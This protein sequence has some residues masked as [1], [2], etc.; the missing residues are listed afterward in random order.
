MKKM[1]VAVLFILLFALLLTS[2]E[3]EL[4]QDINRYFKDKDYSKALELIE[5]GFSDYPENQNLIRWKFY[6]LIELERFDEALAHIEKHVTDKNELM[7][8]RLTVFKK[9]KKYQ[10]ALDLALDRE[11]NSKRRSPWSCFDIIELYLKVNNKE[12]ALD[13]LD[14]AVNRGFISYRFLYEDDFTLIQKEARFKNAVAKIKANIGIG[15]TAKNFSI[16]LLSGR[17]FSLSGQK[18][19]VVLVDFWAT[20]CG[21]CRAEIPNLKTYFQELN[22]K[23]FEIIGVSLDRD[24]QQ[25]DDYIE[26]EQLPWNISFSGQAWK[27][28]TAQLY[29]VNSIPSYWLIDKKGILRQFGLRGEELK[30]AIEELLAE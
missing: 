17:T 21:P 14:E 11:K 5:K 7:G 16:P 6:A 24:R 22:P 2:G 28:E 15:Q 30:K 10:E 13:W 25:L 29:G 27:D 18:G 9:Q 8:A 3:N 20:W 4:M 19:K 26:K 12:K 1:I 23:G